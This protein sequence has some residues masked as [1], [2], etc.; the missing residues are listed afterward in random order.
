[1]KPKGGAPP[2]SALPAA[3]SW[4][5]TGVDMLGAALIGAGSMGM[6]SAAGR[7]AGSCQSPVTAAASC[8][9]L[10]VSASDG[11]AG[12]AGSA[13]FPPTAGRSAGD[14]DEVAPPAGGVG[15]T[16]AASAATVAAASGAGIAGVMP[17]ELL[18]SAVPGGGSPGALPS[19]DVDGGDGDGREPRVTGVTADG[20]STG[21]GGVIAGVIG[22][23]LAAKLSTTGVMGDGMIEGAS[24]VAE[25]TTGPCPGANPSV[26]AGVKSPS[27][28]PSILVN[29]FEW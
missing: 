24:T 26:T 13:E 1:M 17:D 25:G 16:D 14:A 9:S 5:E 3:G 4:D 11:R 20:A 6:L 22:G 29:G 21:A 10:A 12:A 8:T 28:M 19:A 18:R 7:P 15:T 23:G 27:C 2:P